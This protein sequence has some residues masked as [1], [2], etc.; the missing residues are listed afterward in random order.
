MIGNDGRER[1]AVLL[2]VAV[3]MVAL[4]GVAAVALDL[5]G[6]RLDRSLA[7][8]TADN[9]AAA[10]AAQLALADGQAA[11]DTAL[12]YIDLNMDGVMFSG[13]DCTT[14]PASCDSGTAAMSTTATGSSWTASVTYPVPDG[15]PLLNPGAIG[16]TTQS[17]VTDDG[18]QCERIGVEIINDRNYYFAAIIGADSGQTDFHAVARGMLPS[19]SDLAINLLILE[20]Y[21]CDAISASGS[22]A[23]AG[24]IITDAVYNTDSMMLDPGWTASDSDGSG[25]GCAP[26]G[27][28]DVDGSNAFIRA[29]GPPGCPT[30]TGTHIGAAG[31]V[32][33]EGCGQIR[34]LAPGTPGCNQPAC[35]SSGTVNPPPEALSRRVTR[36]PV[37]H[38]YNCKSSYNFGAAWAIDG[39]PDPPA[40][41]ID[42]LVFAYD[43]SGTTP[44]GFTRWNAPPPTGLGHPCN[45]SG[46]PGTTITVSG[47]VHVDCNTLQI[48]RNVHFTGG[49]VIFEGEVRIQAG[50]TLAINAD[51]TSPFP[52]TPASNVAVAFMRNGEIRKAGQASFIAHRTM[53]YVSDTSD[54]TLQGGS[55]GTL[56]WTAPTVGNLDDLALWSEGT[57]NHDF[58]GQ[59]LLELE[60]AFF[61]PWATVVYAGQG[62]QEQVDA[63]FI[64]RKLQSTGQG[65]LVV[66]PSYTRAILFPRKAIVQL[67]R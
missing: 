63:Q 57:A 4:L 31:L 62:V 40:P 21:D 59:A 19:G 61:T 28:I 6:L 48:G 67:I 41:H 44:A 39:C 29:D 52:F 26:D 34:V 11:C 55:T 1:G 60:G 58:A 53:M 66:R 54:L 51:T 17:V 47:N 3:A 10:G 12:A 20:R 46:P 45:V 38:R 2:M 30:Q 23:G 49:D 25:A 64:S 32:V 7:T 16:A 50:G 5:A 65:L 14:M 9:A 42:N 18:V 24:G 33:G 22:G 36:A 27:V 13:A 56:L 15:H 37:D 43:G 8:T 35:T